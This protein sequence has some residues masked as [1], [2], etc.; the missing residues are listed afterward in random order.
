MSSNSIKKTQRPKKKTVAKTVEKQHAEAFLIPNNGF[1]TLR[2]PQ[3]SK[4]DSI[5]SSIY[6]YLYDNLQFQL[7]GSYLYRVV[8]IRPGAKLNSTTYF[9]IH[10]YI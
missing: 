8:T 6:N 3:I 9:L 1:S 4:K 2:G 7:E 5:S 10:L